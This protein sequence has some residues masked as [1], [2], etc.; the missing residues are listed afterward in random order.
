ML[1]FTSQE[2]SISRNGTVSGPEADGT[3]DR[4]ELLDLLQLVQVRGH[5][6]HPLRASRP[7][8]RKDLLRH[9]GE[10]I[11]GLLYSGKI[12]KMPIMSITFGLGFLNQCVHWWLCLLLTTYNEIFVL[13]TCFVSQHSSLSHYSDLY[14]R[15]NLG[16]SQFDYFW[17]LM[18]NFY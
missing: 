4:P 14:I 5:R 13:S 9:Q 6:G 11:L 16:Q 7:L 17:L 10:P 1:L 8:Q 18:D 15:P 12:G 3:A 2:F